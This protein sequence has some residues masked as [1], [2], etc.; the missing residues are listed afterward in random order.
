MR[1]VSH[2]KLVII[3]A[4]SLATLIGSTLL[5]PVVPIQSISS[6]TYKVPPLSEIALHSRFAKENN[7]GFVDDLRLTSEEGLTSSVLPSSLT[8]IVVPNNFPQNE[9]SI[10]VNLNDPNNW[11][12][13][14]NDYGIRRPI[15]GGVY[16]NGSTLQ[17]YFTPYP[18]LFAKGG[19]GSEFLFEPPVATGDAAVVFSK[20][21]NKFI[22][23]SLAFSET[24]C[25]N[26][27]LLFRSSDAQGKNWLRPTV[28]SPFGPAVRT[29]VYYD[30]GQNCST[31]HDKEWIAVDNN[32][33]SPH[34]GRVY[35]T[36]T[37]FTFADNR[38]KKSPIML[39]YSDNDGNTFTGPFEVSG[40]S[41][42]FCNS[43]V[44]GPPNECDENQFSI[45]V[46]APNG[47]SIYVAFEN[48]QFVGAADGFRDQYLVVKINADLLPA[49]SM[50]GPFQAVYPI[51]DG[52]N[53]Y[54]IN[55]DGRQTLCKSNFRVNSAGNLAI[56][57]DRNADG[58]PELYIVFSDNRRHN[59]T[60]PF[61]TFVGAAAPFSCPAGKNTDV[62]VF[63]VKST[64]GGLTWSAPI[65]VNNDKASGT[66]NNRDQWFPWL[67][68]N[69][70][71][72]RLTAVFHDRRLDSSNKLARTFL[73]HDAASTFGSS[74]TPTQ[75]DIA[76]FNSNFDNAF[77]GIGVFIGD[78]N[79]VVIGPNGKAYAAFTAVLA[80]KFDSD[81]LVFRE[82]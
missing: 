42:Q 44:N 75:I 60:F 57:R 46:V 41:S 71:D 49:L 72:G 43:Q 51:F 7:L 61:P 63:L 1:A 70:S 66:T 36:W 9:P 33:T 24:F 54:P 55:S 22:Y 13:G 79:N 64:D 35:V 37:Q 26:G 50:Q 77:F 52:F 12:V 16:T 69:P 29:V 34:Y 74:W 25:E 5:T 14:A 47:K 68:V 39:S 65:Q 81:V 2:P 15:G 19:S 78:Y 3:I 62:D 59:G 21:A 20:K 6:Q 10:A 11:V 76:G 80:G 31:I 30:S 32:A 17:V 23:T 38:Y 27:I 18:R 73:A 4:I 58:K 67:A 56:D 45:P 8:S 48:Q 28:P 40:F 82:P 53:D